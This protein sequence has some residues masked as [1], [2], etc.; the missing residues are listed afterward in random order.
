[1]K[2]E[3]PL[4]KFTPGLLRLKFEG[5]LINGSKEELLER[6]KTANEKE[7]DEILDAINERKLF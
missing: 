2:T 1:M 3:N 6:L 5:L 4:H 7:R